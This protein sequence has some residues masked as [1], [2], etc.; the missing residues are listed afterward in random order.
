MWSPTLGLPAV[1]AP[2]DER[3]VV[4]VELEVVVT[5]ESA[6]DGGEDLGRDLDDASARVALGALAMPFGQLVGDAAVGV[7][8]GD[9]ARVLERLERAVHGAEVGVGLG[10]L[11]GRRDLGGGQVAVAGD[12]HLDHGSPSRRDA[13]TTGAQRVQRR[14]EHV[15]VSR[16]DHGGEASPGSRIPFLP[17]KHLQ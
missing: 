12:Q 14:V 17:A 15:T 7:G 1:G 3:D 9:D 8:V 16:I 10:P 11:E 6:S 13:V 5:T 2:A 4:G